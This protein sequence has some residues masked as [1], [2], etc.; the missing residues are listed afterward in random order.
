MPPMPAKSQDA[1]HLTEANFDGL[2]GPTHNYAGLSFGNV[3]SE[4]N[5]GNASRP[6]DAALQGLAKMRALADMGLVQGIFPP[7]ER[8][9]LPTLRRLGFSGTDEQIIDKVAKEDPILLAQVSSASCM[10]T[11]NAATVAPS[12]DTADGKLHLTVANLRSMAHRFIEGPQTARTLRAIFPDRARVT[13]HD[14]LLSADAFGDEGAANHTRLHGTTHDG[15]PGLGLHLFVY[16]AHHAN[17][18]AKKPAKFPARQTLEASRAVARLH[19]LDPA[20]TI[21]AQQHPDVIDAGAFH[22]DVVA[23]GSGPILFYHEC[24]F[25]NEPRLLDDC[26]AVLGDR[27]CPIR[28]SDACVPVQVAVSTYLFNSQLVEIAGQYTIIAP[29]ES[30]D[31]P[32]VAAAIQ[33]VIDDSANPINRVHYFDLRESM[34]NGGGPACLRLRV[35]MTAAVQASV[36]PGCLLSRDGKADTAQFTKLESWVRQHYRETLTPKDLA[37]PALLR[38][39]HAALDDLTRILGLGSIYEFQ[40][41]R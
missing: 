21:F 22:N 29:T 23:V 26:R 18:A 25:L 24:A 36:A 27:F 19:K 15:R 17:R 10:W 12:T 5:T 9:H 6:R 3:A 35:P 7:Q 38:E 41:A 14:P 16:G 11:A 30:R 40:G 4:S 8:P 28:I 33:D 31:H 39:S 32:A 2:V 1:N 37:D 13:V 20:R 34:R